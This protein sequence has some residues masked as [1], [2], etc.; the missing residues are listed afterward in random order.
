MN[1]IDSIF[2]EEPDITEFRF[3]IQ[4]AYSGKVKMTLA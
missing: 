4:I 3:T 1:K 2:R